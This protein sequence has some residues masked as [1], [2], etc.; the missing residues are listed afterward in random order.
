MDWVD[1]K[2]FPRRRASDEILGDKTFNITKNLNYHGYQKGSTTIFYNFFDK[3]FSGANSLDGAI[4]NGIMLHQQLAKE[5]GKL[6]I[7]KI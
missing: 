6:I 7:R 4:E 5:L 2:D 3:D 1:F